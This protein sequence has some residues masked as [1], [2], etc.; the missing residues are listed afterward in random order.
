M[1]T[2]DLGRPW[3]PDTLQ[4]EGGCLTCK[5]MSG[6]AGDVDLHTYMANSA[7]GLK[8]GTIKHLRAWNQRD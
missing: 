8:T 4:L 6:E 7:N 5:M 2:T 1:L 3:L